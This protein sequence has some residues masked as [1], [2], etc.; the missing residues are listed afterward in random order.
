MGGQT[1]RW[2]SGMTDLGGRLRRDSERYKWNG[3]GE[4]TARKDE[5]KIFAALYMDFK[6]VR[7]MKAE[8]NADTC[9]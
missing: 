2:I 6:A 7:I 1:Y 9:G 8:R 5:K 3:L 4:Q